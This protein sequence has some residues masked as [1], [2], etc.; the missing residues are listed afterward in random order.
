MVVCGRAISWRGC[1]RWSPPK[2]TPPPLA[3]SYLSIVRLPLADST[4]IF[5]L[6]PAITAVLAWLL[7]GEVSGW[8]G[9]GWVGVVGAR[10]TAGQGRGRHPLAAAVAMPPPPTTPTHPTAANRPLPRPPAPLPPPPAGLW[11]SHRRRL[12]GLLAGRG[13]RGAAALAGWRR[14]RRGLVAPARAGHGVRHRWRQPGGRSLHLHPADWQVSG[15]G[16]PDLPERGAWA[17]QAPACRPP[18]A[19]A[20]LDAICTHGGHAH[21]WHTHPSLAPSYAGV[22]TP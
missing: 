4:V 6:S 16:A 15:A 2:V 1:N 3:R 14:R 10:S 11:R 19:A 20:R 7:L 13:P 8:C 12:S 18:P 21:P 5:F 17:P 22:S 9:V